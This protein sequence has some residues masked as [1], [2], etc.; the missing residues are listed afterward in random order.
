MGVKW[1]PDGSL[2]ASASHDKTVAL[3]KFQLPKDGTKPEGEGDD[4]TTGS[5]GESGWL[6]ELTRLYFTGAVEALEF[7]QPVAE[8]GG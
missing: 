3:F 1:S 4:T 8:E 6:V 7:Y 5:S 2:I